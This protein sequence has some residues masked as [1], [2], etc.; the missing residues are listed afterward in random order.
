[1]PGVAFTGTFVGGAAGVADCLT[2][3]LP[4]AFPMTFEGVANFFDG[5]SPA[6]NGE[7]IFATLLVGGKGSFFAPGG[8]GFFKLKIRNSLCLE[9]YFLSLG[10]F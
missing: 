4:G 9:V 1:M 5:D 6:L 8:D 10:C 7:D 2:G 3:N